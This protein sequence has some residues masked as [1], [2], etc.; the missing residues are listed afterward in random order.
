MICEALLEH[1]LVLSR[2]I[3]FNSILRRDFVK[4]TLICNYISMMGFILLGCK[5]IKI[6]WDG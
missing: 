5:M 2:V 6:F 3:Y 1:V 4:I